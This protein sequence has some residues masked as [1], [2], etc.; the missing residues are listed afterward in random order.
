M[1]H[2]GFYLCGMGAGL[3]LGAAVSAAVLARPETRKTAVGKTMQ[4]LGN[5]VDQAVESVTD[6]E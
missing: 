4:R 5:A 1:C 2:T 3:L 6:R